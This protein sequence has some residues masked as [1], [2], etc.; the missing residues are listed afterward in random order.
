MTSL[1]VLL[2]IHICVFS[3]YLKATAQDTIFVTPQVRF[4]ETEK[5]KYF[6]KGYHGEY[7][8]EDIIFNDNKMR[9][10]YCYY[11]DN[12]RV[13]YGY[14]YEFLND[15]ILQITDSKFWQ[16]DSLGNVYWK[17]KKEDLRMN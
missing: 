15:S 11:L 7:G 2:C 4:K 8:R 17:F 9:V 12:K 16:K 3:Q 6:S 1:K 14:T 10:E 5:S 13:S